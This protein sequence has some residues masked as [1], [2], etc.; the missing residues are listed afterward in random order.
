MP[1]TGI[2]RRVGK[3]NKKRLAKAKRKL[4]RKRTSILRWL[5][6]EVGCKLSD[7][8]THLEIITVAREHL[9]VKSKSEPKSISALNGAYA[10]LMQVAFY[11]EKNSSGYVIHKP[12]R[13]KVTDKRDIEGFYKTYSWRNLRYKTVKASN[14]KCAACGRDPSD[15][16]KLNVDHIK[17]V[18]RYWD[19][20]L[21]P[22]NLQV[23]CNECNHGKASWDETDWRE[24][25]LK[26]LMSEAVD[27]DG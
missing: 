19:L 5:E 17:P 16:I 2:N 4:D 27:I 14:G 15:G 6:E 9:G 1:S 11:P 7:D 21:S 23:L 3:V 25:S 24:P 22:D 10:H 13:E 20:R 12:V 18:K 8:P 26:I